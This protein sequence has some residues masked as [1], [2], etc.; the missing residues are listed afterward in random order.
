VCSFVLALPIAIYFISTFYASFQETPGFPVS[1][2]AICLMGIVSI[3]LMTIFAHCRR[4]AA[5]HPIH[6]LRYE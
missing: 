6:T 2:Y 1:L 3:A 4:A 5:R